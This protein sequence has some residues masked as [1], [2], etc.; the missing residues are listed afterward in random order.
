MDGLVD[1][2]REFSPSQMEFFVG[3]G[4]ARRQCAGR[5]TARARR[6]PDVTDTRGRTWTHA[7]WVTDALGHTRPG[8]PAPLDTRA[9]GHTRRTRYMPRHVGPQVG[10]GSLGRG[11]GAAGTPRLPRRGGADLALEARHEAPRGDLGGREPAR[12]AERGERRDGQDRRQKVRRVRRE[13]RG[14]AHAWGPHQ[15]AR[16]PPRRGGARA[17]GDL[18]RAAQR[19]RRE[20]SGWA[21]RARERGRAFLGRQARAGVHAE[22]PRRPRDLARSDRLRR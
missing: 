5:F 15:G 6:R 9:L 16:G 8:S 3:P 13:A 2:D 7:P 1:D 19:T 21:R 22:G 17:R 11:E 12:G 20:H 4:A 10:S 18:A 14:P